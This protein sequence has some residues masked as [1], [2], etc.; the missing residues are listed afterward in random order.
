MSVHEVKLFCFPINH[1][2]KSYASLI[3]ILHILQ[4]LP[5][6]KVKL[7]IDICK[8]NPVEQPGKN[9]EIYEKFYY[10]VREISDALS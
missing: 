6:E 2:S 1:E 9:E 3:Y 7:L 8:K 10:A 5:T 4:T